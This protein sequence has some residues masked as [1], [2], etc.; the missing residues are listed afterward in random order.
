MKP[1]K[2]SRNQMFR[3]LL[4]LT[5]EAS[6]YRFIAPRFDFDVN[7]VVGRHL[8]HR[9]F[10]AL[11][12]EEHRRGVHHRVAPFT[13]RL[14]WKGLTLPVPL[15]DNE[16]AARLVAGEPFGQVLRQR[17]EMVFKELLTRDPTVTMDNVRRLLAPTEL[18]VRG[19]RRLRSPLGPSE[20][21]PCRV[22]LARLR[23]MLS[24]SEELVAAPEELPP[25]PVSVLDQVGPIIEKEGRSPELARSFISHLLALRERFC[26]C[27]DDLAPGQLVAIALDLRDRR[28]NLKTGLRAHLPVRLTLYHEAEIAALE[29][30]GPWDRA[31]VDQI[32]QRRVARLLTESYC[33]G[34]LLSLMLVGVLTHQTSVR[35]AQLVD[36][37][38][39]THQLILP[40]PG[41]IHDAG[42]KLTH[43]A[44][45]V[46]MHLEG[47]DCKE[48][49]RETFH[50][51]EAAG[52]YV[53]DFERTLIA[54]AHGI[55]SS[56]LPHVLKLGQHVVTQ[57]EE[58]IAEHLGGMEQVRALLRTRGVQIEEDAA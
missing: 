8:V 28:M 49:A 6:A 40:T 13:L 22:D 16:L 41:T 57:Y 7:S 3:S 14:D 45:I 12:D 36:Q 55:P 46:R 15:L 51:E 37:F 35:I 44:L 11:E 39:V 25:P 48:I 29:Q 10:A 21:D 4:D 19:A 9:T 58:L 27:L 30:L 32:L 54:Y 56:L 17:R 47:M 52:R 23:S 24:V 1:L 53:D 5:V 26:P 20:T 38:E 33:Q 34:G 42:S 18:L 2:N 50:S 31:A 43:K